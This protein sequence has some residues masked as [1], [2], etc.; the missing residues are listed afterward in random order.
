M[1]KK[2]TNIPFPIQIEV[3]CILGGMRRVESRF[4]H[5]MSKTSKKEHSNLS[6]G[7]THL[8]VW[9]HWASFHAKLVIIIIPTIGSLQN[10][11]EF[12]VQQFLWISSAAR[13]YFSEGARVAF[14]RAPTEVWG[15]QIENSKR[16][17]ST[18]RFYAIFGRFRT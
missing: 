12:S 14:W 4:P 9:S 11:N 18:P 15:R 3:S 7:H 5:L 8:K 17:P 13:F 1:E 16:H 6:N 2:L 10:C